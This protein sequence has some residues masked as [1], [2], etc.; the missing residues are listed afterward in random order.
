MFIMGLMSRILLVEDDVYL[1]DVYVEAL[2]DEGFS[3]ETAED[4]EIAFQ[5]L[6]AEVWDLVLL[7]LTL[8]KLSGI[9]VLRK[10]R[11]SEAASRNKNF[12]IVTNN[13][14]TDAQDIADILSFSSEYLLKSDLTPQQFVEK[15]KGALVKSQ[16]PAIPQQS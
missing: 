13:T 2:T 14:I 5:K 10:I 15:V 12:I 6:E 3:V 11:T 1:R 16:S 7:D 9:E 4:G 8:P